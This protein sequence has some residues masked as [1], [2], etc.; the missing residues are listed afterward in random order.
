MEFPEQKKWFDPLQESLRLRDISHS[1]SQIFD[2]ILWKEELLY[3]PFLWWLAYKKME[4]I[5]SLMKEES[6]QC[7]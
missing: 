2:T 1:S 3:F 5:R 6:S 7:S 4:L